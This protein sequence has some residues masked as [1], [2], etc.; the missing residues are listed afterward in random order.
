MRLAFSVAAHLEPEILIIDEV[1]SV[2]DL[3][4]QEKCLGRMEQVS[5]EGRTVIFISHN[6]GSVLALCDKAVLLSKG[7]VRSSGPVRDVV[8]DY[9]SEVVVAQSLRLGEREDRFGSGTLRFTD[10]WFEADGRVVDSPTTGADCDIV[11]GYELTGPSPRSPQFGVMFGAL[12]GG[13]GVLNL[14]SEPTGMQAQA[15]PPSGRIR[16]SVPR[17]PL[18]AAQYYIHALGESR[19]DHA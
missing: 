7:R 4:F 18:P 13:A 14:E 8:D 5:R 11:L 15:L 16:C 9:V 3:A 12:A 10:I 2:G 1:L 19:R 17:F 6:L